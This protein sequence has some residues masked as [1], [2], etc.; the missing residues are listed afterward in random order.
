[1]RR[2]AATVSHHIVTGRIRGL[3]NRAQRKKDIDLKQSGQRLGRLFVG[4]M[5][6]QKRWQISEQR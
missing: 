4:D 1:M 2:Q 3:S 6:F 5:T